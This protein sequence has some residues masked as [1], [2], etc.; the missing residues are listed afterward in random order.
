MLGEHRSKRP[1]ANDDKIEVTSLDLSAAILPYRGPIDTAQGFVKTVADITADHVS[2]EVS[3]LRIRGGG[4][5]CISC[6]SGVTG[7]STHSMIV[8]HERL[9]RTGPTIACLFAATL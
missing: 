3:P 9:L 2:R 7:F 8:T 5:P 4:H 1:P 6:K